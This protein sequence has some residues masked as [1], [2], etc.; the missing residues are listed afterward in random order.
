MSQTQQAGQTEW[1]TVSP[2]SR[3]LLHPGLIHFQSWTNRLRWNA[4]VIPL[5][6]SNDCWLQSNNKKTPDDPTLAFDAICFVWTALGGHTAGWCI[7]SGATLAGVILTFQPF[8]HPS[9]FLNVVPV[10]PIVPVNDSQLTSK[11]F[12][13]ISKLFKYHNKELCTLEQWHPASEGA[14][15]FIYRQ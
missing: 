4:A 11:W 12:K 9:L 7:F 10:L 14:D 6:R 3:P 1:A 2:E 15:I 13:L 5:H 8:L